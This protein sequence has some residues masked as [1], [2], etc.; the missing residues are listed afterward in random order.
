MAALIVLLHGKDTKP[1]F[2]AETNNT[3]NLCNRWKLFFGQFPHKRSKRMTIR[4]LLKH[5]IMQKLFRI[6]EQVAFSVVKLANRWV[7]VLACYSNQADTLSLD[8]LYSLK[9]KH[10]F[11]IHS[12]LVPKVMKL[13]IWIVKLPHFSWRY[14]VFASP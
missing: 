4:K 2:N 10:D 14:T 12:L 6:K 5:Q 8:F 13:F 7:L 3:W 11:M 1:D 9:I